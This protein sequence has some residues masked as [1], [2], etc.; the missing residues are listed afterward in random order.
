[1]IFLVV[2]IGTTP[3]SE[4]FLCDR[5]QQCNKVNLRGFFYREGCN[6]R[7]QGFFSENRK[8]F[9]FKTQD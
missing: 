4:W 2:G 1:M 8:G 7:P 6:R 5:V 3:F 9:C